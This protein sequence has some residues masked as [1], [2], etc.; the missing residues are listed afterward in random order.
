MSD[1]AQVIIDISSEALDRPFT[2]FIPEELRALS[3]PGVLVKVP[4]G[5]SNREVK[6]YIA[7]LT[8][9]P[10]HDAVRI[11]AVTAVLTGE[12]TTLSRL[13]AMAAWMKDTY[14]STMIQAL[15]TVL[16]VKG[17][18]QKDNDPGSRKEKSR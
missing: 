16:P 15:K 3:A 18:K 1:Y 9:E 2:Y 11:K 7:G 12:E 8:D 14:G 5:R 4:F 17:Q 10:P 13:I 6:G